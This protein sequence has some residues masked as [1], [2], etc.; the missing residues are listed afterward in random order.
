M[1]SSTPNSYFWL[2]FRHGAPFLLVII[3]FALL[4]G[5]VGAEA[6]LNLAEVM[7]FSFVVLAGAAQFVAVQMMTDNAPTLIVI[8]TALAV[9]LRMAMYSASLTPHIGS[10]PIWQRAFA[11][12][13]MTDQS[14]AISHAQYE[15]HRDMTMPQKMAYYF[16]TA[17]PIV[18]MWFAFSFVGSLVGKSIPPEYALDFAIPI[19][20][21]ALI[22]PALR[23][24]AHLA[25][26]GVSVALGLAF[27]FMPYNSG[28]FVA[29]IA[30][31]VT[32]AQVE[33][34]TERR[35]Q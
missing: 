21:L 7:G 20:F 34:W 32:G 1:P 14:Y 27:A 4:F 13:L 19:T 24:L 11:A 35:K 12:Y 5:V 18:P 33:L 22:A 28:L 16:G 15:A 26:A 3:P 6:G 31:M 29:A 10:A 8:V 23:T 9:N 17:A 2:G 30:A 25:A